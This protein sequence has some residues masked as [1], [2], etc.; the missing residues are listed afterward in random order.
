MI[1]AV[2]LFILVNEYAKIA[3]GLLIHINHTDFSLKMNTLTT[4]IVCGIGF[5]QSPWVNLPAVTLT[6][7]DHLLDKYQGSL[8][9]KQ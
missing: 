1:T 6:F 9:G 3:E 4:F 5:G 8:K 2:A 7:P